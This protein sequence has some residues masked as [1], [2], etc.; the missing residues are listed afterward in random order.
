LAANKHALALAHLN[1]RAEVVAAWSPSQARRDA[2][3][4]VHAMPVCDTLDDIIADPS[5]GLVLILT[6]PFTH[7]D[8]VRR[9]AAMGKHVLLEKPIE[10]T[11][12]RSEALV[13]AGE[14]AGIKL[15]VVLQNRWRTP[16]VALRDLIRSGAL[17]ELISVNVAI[18][19]WRPD[20]YFEEPGRG[21]KDRDGGGVMLTQGIHMMDQL[22]DLA[23]C[24]QRVV[25][26]A[27]TSRLRRIDTEDAVGAALQW[28]GGAIGV[29]DATTTRFPTTGEKIDIAAEHGSATLERT[30][31]RAWLKDGR[32]IDIA[33][34]EADPA[35][36]RDYLAHRRLIV[37]MLDAIEENRAPGAAGVACLNV[38]RLIEAILRSSV[39]GQAEVV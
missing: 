14:D 18:R 5:I 19:W 29:L 7:L 4:A 32:T 2:F 12:E 20:S 1:D 25:G 28:T 36:Q 26:F 21:I 13:R 39:S 9:C 35:V 24:P 30:R 16:H 38:H 6:P 10:G 22:V 23:G 11:L 3:A 15:G 34:D 27:A 8:L 37:D 33:E 17:G 31:L